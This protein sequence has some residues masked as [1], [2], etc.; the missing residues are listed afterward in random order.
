MDLSKIRIKEH[1][2][3]ASNDT[4]P[5]QFNF[6]IKAHQKTEVAYKY[7]TTSALTIPYTATHA[8]DSPK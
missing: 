3:I 1:F 8:K 5:K 6:V 4:N 2:G 7:K